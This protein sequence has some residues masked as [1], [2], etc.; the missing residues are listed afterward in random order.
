MEKATVGERIVKRLHGFAEVLKSGDAITE[1]FT[2][3]RVV[4]NLSP[5]RYDPDLVRAT[6]DLLGA[7]QPM[8]AQFLGASV[9]TVRSWEQGKN[10]PNDM[11]CRFM[12]EIRRNPKYW[13]ERFRG[14]L[15][16]K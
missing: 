4:L 9:Q 12:D 11:A 14:A 16:T 15:V 3:R 10:T 6:R 8:F 7:S 5:T 13:L 1:K 2:C